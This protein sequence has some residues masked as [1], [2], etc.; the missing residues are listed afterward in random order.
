MTIVRHAIDFPALPQSAHAAL[1]A[2][3]TTL[4]SDAL[5]GTATA[6]TALTPLSSRGRLVGQARTAFCPGS[7]LPAIGTI[8]LAR[9]GEVLVIGG[10]GESFAS[11][12]GI[13]ARDAVRQK[14]AGLV[15]DGLV[16]DI[17]ELRAMPFPIFCRGA[18]PHGAGADPRGV[19]D[20][21]V[22]LGGAWVNPGDVIVG[23]N[24]G[25]V[26]IAI[27]AVDDVIAKATAKRDAEA[28]W[29]AE[30]E[31]GKSLAEVHGFSVPEP[32]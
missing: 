29:I 9:P 21:P 14:L 4:L 30:I 6:A 5:G 19:I 12:G 17:A 15:I 23:D 7:V 26:V 28:G 24:D 20:G 13:M 31:A 25:I 18:T 3:D 32:T 2:L 8:T 11:L 27:D 10:G 22:N 16:R 1:V